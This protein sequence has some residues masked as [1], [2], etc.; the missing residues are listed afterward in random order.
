MPQYEFSCRKC[1]KV[2]TVF[3]TLAEYEKGKFACPHCKSKNVEQ[4]PSTFQA[5]TSKK[6]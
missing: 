3:L 1:A 5:V 2:F 4:R 6:S